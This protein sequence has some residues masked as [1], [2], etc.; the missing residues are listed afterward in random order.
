MEPEHEGPRLV[1]V[2][3][4]SAGSERE[5]RLERLLEVGRALVSELDLD[6]VLERVLEAAREVT[7]ARYAALGVLAEDR[8]SLERFVALGIDEATHRAIGDLPRGRGVL[9]VLI[10][11]PHPLRLTDVGQHPRSYGF[12]P[13]HPPMRSFLGAPILVRGEAYGNLYLTEKQG[14]DFD[15]QDEEAAVILAEWAAVAIDNAHAYSTAESRRIEL[16]R[17][18]AGLE[19]TAEVAQALVGQTDLA[20]VLELVVKRG[21]ALTEARAMVVLL[22]RGSE[23]EIVAAA[24]ELDQTLLGERIPVDGSISGHVLRSGRPERLADASSR[25]RF[26]LA[27]QTEARAGMFVPLRFRGRAL[28]VLAAFDRLRDGPEFTDW[29]EDVMTGFAASAAAAVAT[30]QDVAEQALRRSIAAAEQ[31]RARWARELHDDTLQELAALKLLLASVR[32]SSDPEERKALLEHAVERIDVGVRSLRGLITDLRPAALD[33]LGLEPALEALAERAGQ[34]GSLSVDLHVDLAFDSGRETSRLTREVEDAIYRLVQEA[35]ANV[36]K[37]SGASHAAVTVRES[38]E[39]VDVE[40]RDEGVGF[41]ADEMAPGFG[42]L[43]MRERVALF[44][45]TITIET[46]P[47][48]GTV[49]RLSLPVA[50]AA[51]EDASALSA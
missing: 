9:G 35:L 44:G 7:G 50:R 8:S 40:V 34:S 49:L 18:V 51:A 36:A 1:D 41:D 13:G 39:T 5:R 29:D 11:D 33:A 25:L 30:A 28:G 17:A 10:T 45:G 32:R 38:A 43:G 16:E 20:H 6:T 42:I 48:A 23:L 22:E 12:P 14:G 31:E 24:G 19:A 15:E 37:H 21:R 26:A 47:G 27:K 3:Q 46:A 4:G 2:S